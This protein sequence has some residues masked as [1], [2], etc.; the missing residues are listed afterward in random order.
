MTSLQ[1][2]NVTV[3]EGEFVCR[4]LA[5]QRIQKQATTAPFPLWLFHIPLQLQTPSW[6]QHSNKALINAKKLFY[7]SCRLYS[8][9][10]YTAQL[11]ISIDLLTHSVVSYDAQILLLCLHLQARRELISSP[12]LCKRFL[13]AR[14][15]T[16]PPSTPSLLLTLSTEIGQLQRTTEPRGIFVK[17][18]KSKVSQ[19]NY[20]GF[21]LPS[22]RALQFLL[23]KFK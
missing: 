17:T 5:T 15:P 9:Y 16:R 13:L 11:H 4:V 1:H 10:F 22:T 14:L 20:I 12:S 8:C 3:G 7:D 21:Y 2:S 18:L 23:L 19:A 6:S